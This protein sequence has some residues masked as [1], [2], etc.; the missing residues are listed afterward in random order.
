MPRTRRPASR[1]KPAYLVDV[2]VYFLAP[3]AEPSVKPFVA[4]TGV[5][6]ELLFGIWLLV[7]PPS[8]PLLDARASA[9]AAATAGPA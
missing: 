2:V 4:I 7:K 1:T 3:A 8:T 9:A 5:A 6:A